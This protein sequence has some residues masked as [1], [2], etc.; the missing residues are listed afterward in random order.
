MITSVT[1]GRCARVRSLRR[2]LCTPQLL[3]HV[4]QEKDNIAEFCPLRAAIRFP[5]PTK[6]DGYA[7]AAT[8]K[9]PGHDARARGNAVIEHAV[10]HRA[11][12]TP[13]RV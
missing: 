10:T 2:Q 8:L 13:P 9:M 5:A 12:C 7:H 6:I 1:P 3:R 4:A 11:Q